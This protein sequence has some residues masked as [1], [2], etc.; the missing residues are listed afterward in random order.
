MILPWNEALF[1]W[2]QSVL[3]QK[4]HGTGMEIANS[5]IA[6]KITFD[7]WNIDF[8]SCNC[9]TVARGFNDVFFVM[10][11]GCRLVFSSNAPHDFGTL[12]VTI[13]F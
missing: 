12:K 4:F 6:S 5:T 2:L 1:H 9:S 11:M 7:S 10:K 8:F 3:T 13:S